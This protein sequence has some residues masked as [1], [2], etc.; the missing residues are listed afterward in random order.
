MNLNQEKGYNLK[1]NIINIIGDIESKNTSKEDLL[2]H[3]IQL[4]L[5]KSLQTYYSQLIKT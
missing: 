2:S 5:N 1:K 4:R 3:Y